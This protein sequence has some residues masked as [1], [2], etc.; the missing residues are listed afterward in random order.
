[1]GVKVSALLQTQLIEELGFSSTPE[2]LANTLALK[3]NHP[4]DTGSSASLLSTGQDP[5]HGREWTE[6]ELSKGRSGSPAG[7][8]KG[9]S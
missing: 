8:Q 2:G 6:Y 3:R 7:T 9:L 4:E 1:M 5:G